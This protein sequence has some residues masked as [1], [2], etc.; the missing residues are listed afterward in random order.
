MPGTLIT[1]T[2][3]A[4]SFMFSLKAEVFVFLWLLGSAK[5]QAAV[6]CLAS[7]STKRLRRSKKVAKAMP[8]TAT[9]P[10][11]SAGTTEPGFR[12]SVWYQ[13][14]GSRASTLLECC[15]YQVLY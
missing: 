13:D 7:S 3:W 8:P 11:I 1:Y 14:F 12:V 15:M 2:Y 5:H 4:S 10:A 6:S 9:N